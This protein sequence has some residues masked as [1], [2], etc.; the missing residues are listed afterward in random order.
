MLSLFSKSSLLMAGVSAIAAALGVPQDQLDNYRAQ[1]ERVP[2]STEATAA[3][4]TAVAQWKQLQQT[5]SLSF[6][7]YSQFLLAHPGWP[8]EAGLRRAAE[9]ALDTGS[10]SPG[11]AVSYFRRFPPLTGTGQVRYAEALAAVGLRDEANAAA[12]AAWAQGTLPASDE[13]KI[14][15]VFSA[16][17]TPADHDARMDALLWAGATSA[18]QRQ[19]SYVSADKRDVFAARLA[20]RSNGAEASALATAPLD[21]Y[22]NDAGYLA[23]RA[24]WLKNNNAWGSARAMLAQPRVLTSRPGKVEPWYEILLSNARSAQADGQYTLAYDIARQV[25]DAYPAGTDVSVRP[26]GERD[27]YTSLVWLAGQTALHQLG[28][29]GDAVA[30]FE[31]YAGGSQTPQTRSKG[32]FWAGRAAWI[33]GKR[34]VATHYFERAA[35]YRDQFYGQ[36]AA[37]NLGRALTPPPDIA[38]RP[39]DQATRDA[40]YARETVRA[41]RYLGTVGAHEDQTAFVRQIALDATTDSDHALATE[42]S[43]TLGRPDL[44][45]M[46]GRS[47]LANGLPDYAVTGFPSVKVPDNQASAWTMIHAIARQESQFDRAAISRAGARGLMQ[48]MPGTARDTATKLGLAYDGSALTSDTDYNIQLGST[49]FQRMFD[50]Y[51]SYPLAVAAYNAGPGNVNKW[52]KANGDP[53]TGAVDMIDWIEAIPIFE[54]KNYVQRVLENAVVYDLLNPARSR[55]QGTARM[56]WYL[57]R[58]PGA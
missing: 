52:L 40:F 22:A 9:R 33:A 19:L 23:D 17:L 4:A 50:N 41:A 21:R 12:R 55:S 45:V 39:V 24:T 43:R 36:L 16:A 11:V 10:W 57:G 32:Y 29:P 49:Y 35:G 34:D 37:E 28:R 31:R 46:V 47:A 44:G 14:L 20:F 54:T 13:A 18:A 58:R 30:L 6:T 25:D 7:S 42:L 48:L 38:A 1:L 56:S 51:G 3:L 15:G 8:G 27:D 5:D 2:V 26:Y 53:R